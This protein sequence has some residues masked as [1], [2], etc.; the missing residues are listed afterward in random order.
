MH[1]GLIDIDSHNWPNLALMKLST[2]HKELGDTVELLKP[3]DVLTY[4]LFNHYDKLYAACIFEENRK[5]AVTLQSVGIEVGGSGISFDKKLPLYIEKMYPDYDLYGIK[6]TAYGFLTR[7]CPRNCRF[8]IV[9]AKEGHTSK[10]VAQLDQFW[11]GQKNIKLLDPNLLACPERDFLLRQLCMS[12]AWID[13]TQGLDVRYIN[14]DIARKLNELN[15]D[16]LH[17]AWDNC[18]VSTYECLKQAKNWLRFDERKMGVYVLTNFN[19]THDQDLDRVYKLRELGY[20]PYVMIYDKPKAQK[21]TRY[22]QRW[23]NNKKIFRTIDN[24]EDYDP[25]KG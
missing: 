24:F 15:I 11:R 4:S 3:S 16:K 23:V 1:V 7:G 20:T 5:V 13:F 25:R 9:S 14:A 19:T 10:S 18:D 12:D 22:L 6:D 21:Q 17:F 8:C 2:Y